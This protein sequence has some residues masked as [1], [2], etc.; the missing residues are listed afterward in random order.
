[1]VINVELYNNHIRQVC[2]LSLTVAKLEDIIC[3]YPYN[4][5]KR[6]KDQLVENSQLPPIALSFYSYIYEHDTVPS[7]ETL[8]EQYLSQSYFDVRVDGRVNVTYQGKTIDVLHEGLIARIYRTYPSIL[9]DFHFYLQ[10]VESGYFQ[11]VKYSFQDDFCNGIDIKVQYNNKWFNVA[12][13]QNTYRSLFFRNKKKNRHESREK[14][15]PL[16]NIELD[17]FKSK[18]CGDY[19]LYT[20]Q[21]IKLLFDRIN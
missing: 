16:I 18:R 9:R 4:G 12:L 13:M 14:E 7:P 10:C 20:P 2:D 5:E 11:A 17:Q 8:I 6:V 3:K 21:H 15:Q 1:V 19:N